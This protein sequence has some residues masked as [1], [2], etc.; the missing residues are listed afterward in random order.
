MRYVAYAPLALACCNDAIDASQASPRYITLPLPHRLT[1]PLPACASPPPQLTP[2][3][4]CSSDLR[5]SDAAS[6]HA[7]HAAFVEQKCGRA[8]RDAYAHLVDL[9]RAAGCMSLASMVR[10]A[11]DGFTIAS[12]SEDDAQDYVYGPKEIVTTA[13]ALAQCVVRSLHQP[14]SAPVSRSATAIS[15]AA[16]PPP[17][18]NPFPAFSRPFAQVPGKLERAERHGRSR[19][20]CPLLF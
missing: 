19:C 16:L 11:C 6:A 20:C 8:A 5:T 14:W 15:H 4:T 1:L 12:R 17:A 10:G 7:P 2:H 13:L 9:A 3:A 18:F